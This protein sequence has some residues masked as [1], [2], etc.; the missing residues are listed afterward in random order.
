MNRKNRIFYNLLE[1]MCRA[2]EQKDE[3]RVIDIGRKYSSLIVKEYGVNSD[4]SP[5]DVDNCLQSF[6]MAVTLYRDKYEF[7][8][9]EGMKRFAEVKKRLDAE[10]AD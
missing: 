7:W 8:M 4:N 10:P 1:Q 5:R 9:K 6:S 2:A 3:D